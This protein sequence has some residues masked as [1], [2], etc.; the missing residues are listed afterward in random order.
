MRNLLIKI[1]KI[2]GLIGLGLFII[3]I[4]AI[5]IQFSNFKK[6]EKVEIENFSITDTIPFSY[7][8]SGHILID[9]KVEG[10]ERTYPFILDSGASNMIFEN[11]SSE[12]N[13]KNN[14]IGIGIGVNG[15]FFFTSIKKVDSFKI[16]TL[17]FENFNV[18]EIKQSFDCFDCIY[19]II[20]TGLMHQ[21]NWQI[22]F[23][24]KKI[25]VSKEFKNLNIGT[26]KIELKLRENQFSH[27]I[28]LPIRFS[29]KSPF[30]YVNVDLGNSGNLSLNENLILKDSLDLEFRKVNGF[31]TSGL[32]DSKTR[33]SNDKIYLAKTLFFGAN[34][35]IDNFSFKS[36]P[37]SLD[38]LGLGFF[39]N[40]KTTISWQHKKLILEPYNNKS[41]FLGKSF[42]FSYKYD[43]DTQKV[44][45]SSIIEKSV[46]EKRD[47]ILNSEIIS[48]NNLTQIDKS[49]FCEIGEI[50]AVNDTIYLSTKYENEVNKYKL[51]KEPLFDF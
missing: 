37:N 32:G 6:L 7:S 18:A 42:G 16:E 39:K 8:N 11:K 24:N 31:R 34:F 38:L 17:E 51:I 47:L 22:D 46:A 20:G 33:V 5:W 2:V 29:E 15:S 1:L 40:Y 9:V 26:N 30:S 19:G 27:H 43:E 28:Q 44:L 4:I 45:V 35:N 23:Q 14:G 50:M 12:F 49:N 10:S 13:F 36:N 21:L 3:G 48:L 25:I 41:D